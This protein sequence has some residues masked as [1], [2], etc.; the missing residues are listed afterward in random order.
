[1]EWE[2]RMPILKNRDGGEGVAKWLD[3]D[4]GLKAEGPLTLAALGTAKVT[5]C[6]SGKVIFLRVQLGL[7]FDCWPLS[8]ELCKFFRQQWGNKS[9]KMEPGGIQ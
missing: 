6:F 4:M 1:M 3:Q 9:V 2:K 7:M 5:P 8:H